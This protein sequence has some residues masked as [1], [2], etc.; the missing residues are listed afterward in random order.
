MAVQSAFSGPVQGDPPKLRTTLLELVTLLS[1]L[2]ESEEETLAMARSLLASGRVQ[3][4]GNFR[5]CCHELLTSEPGSG[6]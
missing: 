3:L 6:S 2:T 4:T 1:H 5:G